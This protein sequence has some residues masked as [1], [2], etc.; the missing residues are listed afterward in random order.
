V[1]EYTFSDQDLPVSDQEARL[2][3]RADRVLIHSPGLWEKKGGFNRNSGQLPNGV[4]FEQVSRTRAEPEDLRGIARPR[5]GYCGWLK[6]QLD[7]T[8]ID[9]LGRAHPEWSF[10][11]AGDVAP[12]QG[13]EEVI[14]KLERLPNLYFL[15]AKSSPE[16]MA[17]PQHFDVCIMPYRETG[18][19]KYIYPL[20]LHEYLASGRPVVGTPIRTLRD[21]EGAIALARSPEAWSTA[22]T[23]ALSP[24]A[25]GEEAMSARRATARRHDWGVIAHHVAAELATLAGPDVAARFAAIEVPEPWR[26]RPGMAGLTG[27][28]G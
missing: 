27:G 12:R 1:D 13:L 3:R 18:Y 26:A 5:I 23:A 6:N 7:W 4:D 15:G 10:V 14:R 17:Y 8:L 11:F 25:Q 2:L 16:L 20:K 28:H 9:E 22:I 24:T 21:F 19:T